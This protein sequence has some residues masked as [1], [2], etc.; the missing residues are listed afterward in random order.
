MHPAERQVSQAMPDK[1]HARRN[2]RVAEWAAEE[3]GVLSLDELRECRLNRE[4]VRR[5]VESGWLHPLYRAVYAVGHPGVSRQGRFLA[6]VKSLGKHAVLSRFSAAALWGFVDWDGRHPEV[7]VPR[8]GIASRR[9]IRVHRTSV[10]EPRD[11][12]RHEGVPVTSP[13]RTLVDLAAV[14]NDRLLRR[15]VRQAQ[16]L[17]RVSVPQLVSTLRRLGPRRG[18]AS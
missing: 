5:R 14:V 17:R 15:A 9:G 4:A 8:D 12:A 10:L 11:I 13:A 16:S 2:A 6:A 7:T 18:T 1:V 3:W